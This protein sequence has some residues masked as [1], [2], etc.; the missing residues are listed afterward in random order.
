MMTT[1]VVLP[2][3]NK[4]SVHHAKG[5]YIW[6]TMVNASITYDVS[7][8]TPGFHVHRSPLLPPRNVQKAQG[9]GCHLFM[10]TTMMLQCTTLLFL[11]LI[12]AY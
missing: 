5:K 1:R 9:K 12:E 6:T 7:E 3:L 4:L 10:R 8:Q 2:I 11:I